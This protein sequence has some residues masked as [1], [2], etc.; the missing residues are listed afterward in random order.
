MS[1][2]ETLDYMIVSLIGT[3][4]FI[5]S[6]ILYVNNKDKALSSRLLAGLLLCTSIVAIVCTLIGTSFF[7]KYPQVWRIN[8]IFSCFMPLM[9]YLYVQS[10]LDQQFRLRTKDYILAIPAIICTI[11]FLPFFLLPTDEK[12]ALVLKLFNSKQLFVQEI[13][14][15]FPPG[16]GIMFR[17][18]TGFLF[19]FFALLK[20]RK[21]KIEYIIKDNAGESQNREIYNWLNYLVYCIILSFVLTILWTLMVLLNVKDFNANT[22]FPTAILLTAVG[23]ITLICGYLLF[24]PNILYG[25]KGW[26]DQSFKLAE[27]A[28][29][30]QPQQ[31]HMSYQPKSSFFQLK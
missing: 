29:N 18:V 3:I 10:V 2:T 31:I 12:R 25:L 28:I 17:L 13:D 23:G 21:C 8:V 11:N 22:M 26:V 19:C 6:I 15:L 4:G 1:I 9:L 24:K 30:D 7:V 20:V 5:V 27:L 14:G 16:W